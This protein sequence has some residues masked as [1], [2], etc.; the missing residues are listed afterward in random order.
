MS[1]FDKYKVD[2]PDG[3]SGPWKVERFE[4]SGANVKV[5]NMR[6]L[7]NSGH[8]NDFI[9]PGSYTRL[10]RYG[11]VIMSDTMSE[12]WDHLKFIH[13]ARGRVLI[14]GLGLGMVTAAVCVKEEVEHVTVIEK[15]PDVIALVAPTLIER[16]GDKLEIIET[17]IF[18]WKPPKGVC[19]DTAWY[20]IW[21]NVCLDNLPQ[22]TRLH[23]KFGRRV[24]HQASWRKGWLQAEK[25]RE[26]R[27]PLNPWR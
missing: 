18:E 14:V 3:K 1:D 25:R 2:I 6:A 10:T 21:D 12:I 26:Q 23:R 17:D 22:M 24:G 4:I 19:W 16:Y 20:D 8:H 15:S 5:H 27:H 13:G 7:I 9:R 11:S